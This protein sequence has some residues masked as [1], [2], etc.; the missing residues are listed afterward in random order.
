MAFWKSVVHRIRHPLTLKGSAHHISLGQ[1]KNWLEEQLTSIEEQR[2][3]KVARRSF[4]SSLDKLVPQFQKEYDHALNSFL[5]VERDNIVNATS[6]ILLTFQKLSSSLS[7]DLLFSYNKELLQQCHR[8][9]A[10]LRTHPTT[11]LLEPLNQK[12]VLIIK[13]SS[14][15]DQFCIKQRIPLYFLLQRRYE[16]LE[17]TVELLQRSQQQNHSLNEQKRDLDKKIE[18][19]RNEGLILQK[20]PLFQPAKLAQNRKNNLEREYSLLEQEILAFFSPLLPLFSDYTQKNEQNQIV[21]SYYQNPI[22]ALAQDETLSIIHYCD[23]IYALLKQDQTSQTSQTNQTSQSSQHLIA[24]RLSQIEQ[25]YLTNLQHRLLHNIMEQQ[26]FVIPGLTK[27]FGMR[28]Q[29]V[30]Y[31][32]DHFVSQKNRLSNQKSQLE[33]RI[34]SISES[35]KSQKKAFEELALVAFGTQI[36]LTL[37]QSAN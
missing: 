30:E 18:E 20:D 35:V 26:H 4:S 32:L 28:L 31:K 8:L 9:C 14:T 21:T 15:L 34:K 7:L 29:E 1:A 12:L 2:K 17:Q 25:G 6:L 5:F 10:I 33:E 24:D 3:T 37:E 13:T 23:H 16:E 22:T 11:D 27:D 19:K 36:E